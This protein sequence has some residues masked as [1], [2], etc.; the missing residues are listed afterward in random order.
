VRGISGTIPPRPGCAS[1]VRGESV[2]RHRARLRRNSSIF[3]PESST[4]VYKVVN[5]QPKVMR[6]SCDGLRKVNSLEAEKGQREPVDKCRQA[7][8]LSSLRVRRKTVAKM[9]PKTL[10]IITDHRNRLDVMKADSTKPN[11]LPHIHHPL[12]GLFHHACFFC[13]ET[14]LPHRAV[15]PPA[16]NSSQSRLPRRLLVR[17]LAERWL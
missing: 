6:C 14:I 4:F 9:R 16:S 3:R 17:M 2:T 5:S 15:Y 1:S 10:T 11:G 12:S 7:Q 13:T 8:I